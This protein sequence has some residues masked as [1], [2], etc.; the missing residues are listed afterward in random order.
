MTKAKNTDNAVTAEIEKITMEL[1]TGEAAELREKAEMYGMTPREYAKRAIKCA[2][3]PNKDIPDIEIKQNHPFIAYLI[4]SGHFKAFHDN[5]INMQLDK[6][7]LQDETAEAVREKLKRDISKRIKELRK[8]TEYYRID[9]GNKISL[10][11]ACN[12]MEIF[13]PWLNEY[14][15]GIVA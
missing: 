13:I 8:I 4:K 12:E 1:T 7:S 3:V 2:P 15:G 11:R 10:E 14:C 6:T 9:T 5:F